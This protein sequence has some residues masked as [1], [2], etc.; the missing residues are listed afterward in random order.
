MR[1]V[2]STPFALV[3]ERDGV[4]QVRAQDATG[5]FGLL[6]RHADF[7][8]A[9]GP[10]VVS[11]RER[12]GAEGHCVVRNGILAMR[13]GHEVAI[14]APE[15]VVGDDLDALERR[16]VAETGALKE[17]EACARAEA[18]RIEI[19]VIRRMLGYLRGERRALSGEAG[20]AFGEEL[21]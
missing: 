8:T 14:A 2:I 15:A 19:A 1:L 16:V 5:S 4:G 11:W 13:G 12:D 7:V 21:R 18:Q 3:V 9:L 10:S 17:E 6:E 20:G